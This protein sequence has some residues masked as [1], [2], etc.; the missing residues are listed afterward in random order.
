MMQILGLVA[1]PLWR[2]SKPVRRPLEDRLDARVNRLVAG[3]ENGRLMPSIVESLADSGKR[4]ERLEDRLE[5]VDH[6]TLNM[7]EEVDLVF[8]GLSREIFRLQAQVEMLQRRLEAI[9]SDGRSGL[10]AVPGLEVETE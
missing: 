8:N 9:E 7:I 2:I 4:L 6:A 1:R 3:R 5:Q 10:G